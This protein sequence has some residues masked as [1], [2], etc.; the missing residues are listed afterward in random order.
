MSR[1]GVRGE[2]SRNDFYQ[3]HRLNLEKFRVSRGREN[4]RIV[5]NVLDIIY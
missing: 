4:Y 3:P 1:N 2:R 5:Y